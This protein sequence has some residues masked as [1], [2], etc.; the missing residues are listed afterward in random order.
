MIIDFHTH[1]FPEKIA[2]RAVA[3]LRSKSHTVSFSDGTAKGLEERNRAAGIDLAVILPVATDPEQVSHVNDRAALLNHTYGQGTVPESESPA[4]RA[5]G[6]ASGPSGLL[7][8]ACIHP[9]MEDT[10]A[11]LYRIHELGFKGIKL[12]PVYQGTDIDS[13]PFLKILDSCAGLGLTVVTHGGWD[14]GFPGVRHCM[15]DQIRRAVKTVDPEGKTLKLVA[16][17]MGG[18]RIWEE[19]PELLADTGVYLD[20]SFSTG[21]FYPLSDGYYDGKDISMLDTEG[22]MTL[23]RAFGPERILF[24]TDNPW[25]DAAESLAF[26]RALPIS[27]EEKELVL[28]GS[29][30]KLLGFA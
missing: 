13:L 12:H 10:A 16:A 29:A 15:P 7:S 25:S 3:S 23:Y 6:D 28:G 17:H 20:T 26:I 18:W 24:G 21:Q 2:E 4:S 27:K 5:S 8:F 11:E 1:T 19:V 14:I 9:E 30:L 22:F